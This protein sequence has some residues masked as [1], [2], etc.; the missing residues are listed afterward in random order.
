MKR[1][2]R[3]VY[4][5][6][7]LLSAFTLQSQ[8]DLQ[9]W[10]HHGLNSEFSNGMRTSEWYAGKSFVAPKKKVIVA[11][12]D[13]GIDIEHPDL[14]QNIWT[15]PREIP[16]NGIDDDGNGYID[17]I[18]GWNFLGSPDGRHVF[19]DTYEVTRLYAREREKWAQVD[20][21]KLKGKKR[22]EYAAF[23]E[24]QHKVETERDDALAGLV[25][26]EEI[27][28][29]LMTALDAAQKAL[30]GDSVDMDKLLRSPDPEVQIAVEIIQNIRDQGVE[31]ESIDWLKDIAREEFAEQRKDFEKAAYYHYNPEYNSRE[32][33]GDVYEDQQNR[34]YGNNIVGG[35]HSHHGT[36]VAGI[37]G[38]IR[39][40]NLG[41]DGVA[42]DVSLMSLRV[43][44]DGDEHDK[45]VANAVYYAVD[46]GA[47]IINMSFGKGY[48]PQ[49]SMVDKAIKYAA[50]HDVLVVVGAGNEAENID[51]KPKFPNDVW[52]K[53]PFLGSRYATNMLSVGALSPMGG[54]YAIAEFSNYGK[55]DVDV[56]SP[57]VYVYSTIPGGGYD[58]ASGTSMAAPAV[59]GVAALIRSRYPALSAVQVK[60]VIIKSSRPL[61]GKVIQPGTFETVSGEDMG[62]GGIVD[63]VAAMELA[64]KL[65]G[66]AKTQKR[67]PAANA[68]APIQPV[69]AT[70]RS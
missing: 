54:E 20:P 4:V 46:N 35:D 27:E 55:K 56:Y 6:G 7:L 44:P 63:I 34:Y 40:N 31:L 53:K 14:R 68:M 45:D 70:G 30:G 25:Q 12:L 37:I 18:H 13:S 10:Q 5:L 2:F 24:M 59:S 3:P 42:D 66:K 19:K 21:T 41:I 64:S 38:A 47:L 43:V 36:H 51:Q 29:L 67:K 9:D 8:G 32:I 49:K 50:R 48:S 16:G 15:N 1:L 39:N 17:D 57:G 65:Q 26:I 23:A 11:V 52:L 33:I 61:P 22:K 28:T 69:S 58:F 62:V 60:E